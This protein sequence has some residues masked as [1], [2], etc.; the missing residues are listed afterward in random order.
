M[1]RCSDAVFLAN[2]NNFG[3]LLGRAVIQEFLNQ[4]GADAGRIAGK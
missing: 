4:F 2:Q 1:G 3:G